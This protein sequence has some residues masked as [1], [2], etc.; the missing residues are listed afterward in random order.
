MADKSRFIDIIIDFGGQEV[1]IA[2]QN[3]VEQD[4]MIV[5]PW[6]L[7]EQVID[8]P[9]MQIGKWAEYI[10]KW[11]SEGRILTNENALVS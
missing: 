4:D 11:T 8:T 5:Y 10:T 6:T 3:V 2:E 9:E 7:V 1:V